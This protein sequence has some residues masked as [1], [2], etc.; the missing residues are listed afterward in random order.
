MTTA[1]DLAEL[2]S[3]KQ[4]LDRFGH[5]FLDRELRL[6]RK[7]GE[8]GWYDLRRGPH[9]TPAQLWAYLTRREK[10]PCRQNGPI[11]E[12]GEEP[13]SEA[14]E[15][16]SG[17]SRSGNSG[18]G[19]KKGPTRS[20]IIGMTPRLEELAA[21]RLDAETWKTPR[22]GSPRMSCASRQMNRCTPTT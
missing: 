22:C 7:R 2:W 12:D 20:T 18:S 15:K 4:V 1:A 5:L 19:K 3:E 9:Y 13:E 17:Y 16:P 14:P 11:V 10:K 6:A 21:R 8:I